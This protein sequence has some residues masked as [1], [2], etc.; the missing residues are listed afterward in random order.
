MESEIEHINSDFF[1][2]KLFQK[3]LD[4]IAHSSELAQE[5]TNYFSAHND[6]IIRAIDIV[7]EFL[8]KK[9]RLCYGGQA[10]NAHLP[11]KY[12]FYD[13]EYSI[14]D[15]DFFTPQQSADI[16]TLV[17]DFKKAG[18]TEIS[19]R[20][21]MHEGT[22]KIYVDYVPVADMTSINNKLYKILSHREFRLDGISYLDANS[23]RMLMYLELS[24]PRGEVGRW[25]KV[26]E[27]L[28]LF[29]EFVP[30][31]SCKIRRNAFKYY[32]SMEQTQCI[33]DFIIEN[34]RIFS[35]ADLLGFYEH[36]LK[37]RKKD[38]SLILTSKKPILFFSPD[39]AT[40]AKKLKTELNF[41]YQSNISVTIKSVTPRSGDL[42]PSMKIIS[43]NNKPIIFIIGQEAC[44][45]Y[46][47]LSVRDDK[48]LRIASMDT[49]I[50]LYFSLGLFDSSLFDMGSMECLAN[51]LIQISIKARN[52]SNSFIFPFISI[53]CA[54]HQT[55]LPSLIRSKVKRITQK[56]QKL[57]SLLSKSNTRNTVK[58]TN[59]LHT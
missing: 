43:Q 46:F 36:A 56:K 50:T 57:K 59:V 23:L 3:Q 48:L 15:Y 58:S 19:V 35:G 16:N 27:R 13:P 7:E 22:I 53:K 31:K 42:V 12:K 28:S 54:G 20:E 25:T 5:R 2:K 40:D 26:Y 29:N 30:V 41:I 9:H 45:S 21:G 14:P 24:R 6:N 10:I 8:R 37:H 4:I 51:Q 32:L 44:S 18:F 11:A 47:N 39:A 38:T 55:S 52:S 33:L 1:D 49:L 34:K 17:A